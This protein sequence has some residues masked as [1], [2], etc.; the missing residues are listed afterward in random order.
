MTLDQQR[1]R[2]SEAQRRLNS[3]SKPHLSR[4]ITG[5]LASETEEWLWIFKT[6]IAVFN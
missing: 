5:Y 1:F 2:H 3:L 4:I 6:L